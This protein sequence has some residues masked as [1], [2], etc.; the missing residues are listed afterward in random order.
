MCRLSHV[1]EPLQGFCPSIQYFRNALRE[2]FLESWVNWLSFVGQGSKVKGPC[3]LPIDLDTVSE[4]D[5]AQMSDL[6][7]SSFS[8]RVHSALL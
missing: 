2:V 8:R 6:T 5:V 4:A 3:D 7:Y 1:Y